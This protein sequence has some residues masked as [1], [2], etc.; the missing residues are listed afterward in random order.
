[1]YCSRCGA[2]LVPGMNFCPNCGLQVG[3][4]SRPGPGPQQRELRGAK[5][6]RIAAFV[7]WG[8]M[9]LDLLVQLCAV[10]ASWETPV[11]M[12]TGVYKTASFVGAPVVFILILAGSVA[13]ALRK[14]P[15]LSIVLHG[16]DL[17]FAV[18]VGVYLMQPLNGGIRQEP[19]LTLAVCFLIYSLLGV[20]ALILAVLDRKAP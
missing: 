6:R 13:A 15:V 9:L 19:L 8:C 20:A 12:P 5:G 17:G 11:I 2:R 1:M 4:A 3:P 16:V 10:F 14:K 7:L 18:Y